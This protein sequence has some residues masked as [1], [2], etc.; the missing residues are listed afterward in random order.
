M[1][2]FAVLTLTA[3]KYG[4]DDIV[5]GCVG[6]WVGTGGYGCVSVLVSNCMCVLGCIRCSARKNM[7]R[8]ELK[9]SRLLAAECGICARIPGTRHLRPCPLGG[10]TRTAAAN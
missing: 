5:S 2:L 4:Y 7:L 9:E 1:P 6:G 10:K 8:L 3:I